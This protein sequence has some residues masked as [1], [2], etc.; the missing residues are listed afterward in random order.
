MLKNCGKLNPPHLNYALKSYLIVK[1]FIYNNSL[2]SMNREEGMSEN[3]SNPLKV[4]VV[5]NNPIELSS[6]FD[7]LSRDK[8]KHIVTE[9]AFNLKTVSERLS[10]FHPDYI[11]IDDNIGKSELK[12]TMSFLLNDRKTKDIPIT[13][14]KN[15]NYQEF[16]DMGILSYVLKDGVTTESLYNELKNALRLRKTQKYIYEAYRKRKGQFIR[17]LKLRRDPAF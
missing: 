12:I 5:G 1:L 6:L 3:Q 11:L 10:K 4:L 15:S 2:I 7:R 17:F 16:I 14:L 8:G 9:T 13:V